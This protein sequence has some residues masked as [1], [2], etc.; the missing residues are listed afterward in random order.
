MQDAFVAGALNS[1]MYVTALNVARPRLRCN[2]YDVADITERLADVS[3]QCAVTNRLIREAY[4]ALFLDMLDVQHDGRWR[5]LMIALGID[6]TGH[7][8]LCS[9]HELVVDG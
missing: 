5:Q 2:R 4:P 7:G 1:M 8:P 3:L 6:S 9:A